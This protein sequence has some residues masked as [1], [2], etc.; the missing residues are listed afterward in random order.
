MTLDPA[1]GTLLAAHAEDHNRHVMAW[2]GHVDA[3]R[4]GTRAPLDPA[5]LAARRHNDALFRA[6][7]ARLRRAL[8]EQGA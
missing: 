4:I 8:A 2:Q 6:R 5:V 3:G 7:A 1:D